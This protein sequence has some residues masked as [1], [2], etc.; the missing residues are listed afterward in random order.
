MKRKINCPTC[1][2][3][4]NLP[5]RDGNSNQDCSQC[6]QGLSKGQ[7]KRINRGLRRQRESISIC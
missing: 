3:D 2:Q 4:M 1:Y 7:L 6:G 5:P